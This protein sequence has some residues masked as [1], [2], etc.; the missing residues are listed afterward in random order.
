M[1]ETAPTRKAVRYAGIGV[2]VLALAAWYL[3]SASFQERM[4]RKVV[5]GLEQMTGARAELKSFRWSLWRLEFE[6]RDLTLHGLESSD[7]APYAH[8]DRLLVRLKVLSLLRYQIG[9]RRLELEHPVVHIIVYPDGSTNQ[10]GPRMKVKGEAIAGVLFELAIDHAQV[11]RGELLWNDRRV[12]L[13]FTARG[14]TMTMS[15]AG[16]AGT[17]DARVQVAALDSKYSGFPPLHGKTEFQLMLAPGRAELRS[18]KLVSDRSLLEARGTLTDFRDPRIELTYSGSLDVVELGVL[19]PIRELR[20]GKLEVSGQAAVHAQDF[21]SAGLLVLKGVEWREPGLSI[22]ELNTAARYSLSRDRLV[23]SNLTAQA[24]GGLITGGAEIINWMSP[25]LLAQTRQHGVGHLRLSRVQIGALAAAVSTSWLPLERVHPA[26]VASGTVDFEWTGSTRNLNA[27]SA[28]EIE[29]PPSPRPGELPVTARMHID[30]HGRQTTVDIAQLSITTRATHFSA[31]GVLGSTGARLSIALNSSDFTELQSVLAALHQPRV[32]LE[33]QGRTSFTGNVTGRLAGPTISG[34]LEISDFDTNLSPG[35]ILLPQATGAVA[36]AAPRRL[37]WDSLAADLLYSPSEFSFHHGVLRRGAALARFDV[38]EGLR[39]GE[40][41]DTSALQGRVSIVGA[42]VQD[43]QLLAGTAYPITGKLSLNVTLGGTHSSPSG[44][45]PLEITGGTLAGEAFQSLRATLMWASWEVKLTDLTL[46]HNGAQLNGSLAY[47]FS[48]DRF[49]F[50]LTGTNFELSKF[51]R[52]QRPRLTMAGVAGF[53]VQGS[54]TV[55]APVINIDLHVRDLVLNREQAGDFDLTGVTHGPDLHLTARSHFQTAE[56]A[57]DGDIRLRGDFPANVTLRFSHLDISPLLR[58]YL[59]GKITVHS[60]IAGTLDLRGPLLRPRDLN[61][62]GNVDQFSAEIQK[63]AVESEGPIHFTL[64]NEVL[65]LDHLH[66]RGFNRAQPAESGAAAGP[67]TDIVAGGVIQ[68][69]GEHEMK[70]HADGT[71]DFG[72]L[73]SLNPELTSS[74][75]MEINVAVTGT[76]AQP[77]TR[78]QVRITNG[79]ISYI[80][81]PNGLSNINGT[82]VFNENR[83]RVQSLTAQTGGG[84][85]AVGGF[86]NYSHGLSFDLTA[87][88]KDIRLRYP[89]GISSY[90]DA[91]LRFSGTPGNSLLSGTVTINRFAVSPQFDFGYLLQRFAQPSGAANEQSPLN[92]LHL[93]LHVVTA[94]EL[95]VEMSMAKLAG[96]A[97]LRLRGTASN[98]VLLGRVNIAQGNIDIAGTKYHLE[99][100][101]L[102][103]NNPTTIAPVVDL[104][105][106]ARV[107]DYD[108]SL[109]EHGPISHPTVSL[110]SDPPLPQSDIIALLALGRTRTESVYSSTGPSQSLTELTSSAVLEQAL[111]SAYSSRAQRL[112]GASRIKID[113]QAGGIENNPNARVNIEQQVSDKVTLTY[114]TS[115]TQSTQQQTVQVEYH[116]NR[117][118]SLVAIRDQNGVVSFDVR[119]RQRRR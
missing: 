117:R 20:R 24:L 46:T 30:Y 94:Q 118:L 61:L 91:D 89:P 82:L 113:P 112:F 15:Y 1:T 71:L 22:P 80:D 4:R 83:L 37:R 42:D 11:D 45:G 9:I 66:L 19:V 65:T 86:I 104:E 73:Q 101:D 18:F 67:T 51:P 81:V 84:T 116:I 69:G 106:T 57:I 38:S 14:L 119:Y 75:Q 76:M 6:G 13:D 49:H 78:G 29:P 63:V 44:Q 109:G 10:P 28:V 111:A 2:A 26:G 102:L 48:D 59:E 64:A 21:T 5:A 114:G 74:G 31:S 77:Q 35:Q 56:L 17:Y 40:L 93:D 105:A 97:D 107:R 50:D 115:V 27:T 110:R 54:G 88:S 39:N 72:L 68:L 98:P 103:F 25:G 16:L 32:T 12:P 90:A 53:H 55:Q 95:R 3:T 92:N 85:L 96:N 8:A 7:Q 23:I 79:A 47:N 70:L 36:P 43:V 62:T 41:E 100:G 34:H 87:A 58:A 60:S 33:V 99:R 108:I 52:L